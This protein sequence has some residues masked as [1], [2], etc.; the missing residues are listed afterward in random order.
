[1]AQSTLP[2][3]GSIIDSHA[4]VVKEYFETDQEEVIQRAFDS[5]SFK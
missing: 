5:G 1:M 4:H 3:S 2:S